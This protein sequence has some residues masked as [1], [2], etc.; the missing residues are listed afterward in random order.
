MFLFP[1]L[2]VLTSVPPQ[3]PEEGHLLPA[4][5]PPSVFLDEVFVNLDQPKLEPLPFQEQT[6]E[7]GYFD[8]SIFRKAAESFSEYTTQEGEEYLW[9][10][11]GHYDYEQ[12]VKR[13][14][15]CIEERYTALSALYF[16]ARH[17]STYRLS[18]EELEAVGSAIASARKELL[19]KTL[20]LTADDFALAEKI[21]KR[22][23]MVWNRRGTILFAF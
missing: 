19:S 11:Q 8:Y 20:S 10:R 7:F 17:V 9:V 2:P 4:A 22:K 21:S 12:S 1:E 23:L 5:M 14:L 18:T 6:E 15:K 13:T 3:S 16:L